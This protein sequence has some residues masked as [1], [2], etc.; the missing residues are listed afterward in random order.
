MAETV[1][2]VGAPPGTSGVEVTVSEPIAGAEQSP[3]GTTLIA[4]AYQ[5]G[6]VDEVIEHSGKPDFNALR[7]K[8]FA[9]DHAALCCEHFYAMADGAGRV[10]TLRLTDG[11]ERQGALSVYGRDVQENKRLLSESGVPI[12]AMYVQGA[13]SGKR[14]GHEAFLAGRVADLSVPFSTAGTF[15]TGRTM[16]VNEYVGATLKMDSIVRSYRITGNTAAGLLSIEVPSGDTGPGA[17]AGGWWVRRMSPDAWEVREGLGLKVDSSQRNPT[18]EVALTTFD[19][20]TLRAIAPAYPSLSLDSNLDSYITEKLEDDRRFRRQHWLAVT[21]DPDTVIGDFTADEL[22]PANWAGMPAVSQGQDSY[23]ASGGITTVAQALLVDGETLVIGDGRNTAITFEFDVAGDGVTSG[24]VILDVSASVT[25]TDVRDV[26]ITAVNAQFVARDLLVSA[27]AYDTDIVQ[28]LGQ[29]CQIANI[30]ITETVANAGFLVT[31]MSGG[32][33]PTNTVYLE[34]EHWTVT[35]T[36]NPFLDPSSVLYGADAW[37]RMRA[38]CTFTAPTAFTVQYETWDGLQV[39]AQAADLPAGALA[40]A[41]NPGGTLLPRFTL[42]AGGVAAVA[43]DVLTVYFNPVPQ[44]LNR[45]DSAVYL[46]AHDQGF[47]STNDTR[48]WMRPMSNTVRAVTMQSSVD[49]GTNQNVATPGVP[50]AVGNLAGPY[51]LAGGETFIYNLVGSGVTTLT[52]TL[53]GAATTAT[54]LAAELNTQEAAANTPARMRFF[55]DTNNFLHCEALYDSGPTASL[56]ITTGTLNVI[57]G[58]IDDQTIYG[59]QGTPLAIAY[60]EDLQY[61]RD[62]I[63]EL[64]DSNEYEDAF[65]LDTSPINAINRSDYGLVKMALPGVSATTGEPEQNRAVEYADARGYNFRREVDPASASDET[66]VAAYVEANFLASRNAPCCWD[67]YGIPKSLPYAGER[68]A[69]PMTGAILGM[70][71]R[72]ARDDKGYHKA[73]AGPRDANIGT[74]FEQPASLV[75]GTFEIPW[76]REDI[77]NPV[78]VQT[79][80]QEGQLIYPNGDRNADTAYDGTVWKHKQETVLQ[81]V[82]QLLVAA[83]RLIWEDLSTETQR[84]A[85]IRVRPLLKTWERRGWYATDPNLTFD[86][87]FKVQAGPD[88]NPPAVQVLGELRLVVEHPPVV[89]TAERVVIALGTGGVTAL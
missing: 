62:G 26:I 79:L 60:P 41:Y 50:W 67:S 73:A 80:Q 25:A 65:H 44:Y 36:G 2:Q 37:H 13:Y 27:Y 4:G 53:V 7:G 87:Q 1:L 66:S 81:E 22:R 63:G 75:A 18:S 39:I 74:L 10:L 64:G 77:L 49:V 54:A 78:G 70:E 57:L 21:A 31:G 85:I 16:L 86:E 55:A 84:D 29:A 46:H 30:A 23:R 71:A 61:G 83:E 68:V 58:L 52:Q 17:V 9:E 33:G 56:L 48:T 89:G 24:N 20:R 76:R 34:T 72:K 28:L 14:G 15:D 12:R 59:S 5:W 38:V 51:N 69:V 8:P 6:P 82:R 35:G 19:M 88:E 40:T 43:T 11:N 42:R 47:A 3:L 32:V 45:L